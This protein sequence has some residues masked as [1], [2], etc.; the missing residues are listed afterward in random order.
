VGLQ[1][2]ANLFEEEKLFTLAAAYEQARPW[3]LLV[4]P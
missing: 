1:V 4:R 2:V 3:P